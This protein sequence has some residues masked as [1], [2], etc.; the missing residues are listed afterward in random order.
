MRTLPH[1]YTN[2][3]RSDGAVVVKRYVGPDEARRWATERDFLLRL[4]GL[5]PVP[6]VLAARPGE[7]HL[8]HLPGVHGQELIAAGRAG[9][10]LRSC[11][12]LVTRLTELGVT[13]SDYGP[14]NM[15]F[16]PRTHEV[17]AILDWE[18]AHEGGT[19]LEDLAWCEWIV[20][21]HHPTE[22][23][24]L[25]ELYAGYGSRPPWPGRQAAML[26]KC[27]QMLAL[28]RALGADD[29]GYARWQHLIEAT[30]AWEELT[31]P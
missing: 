18:W 4:A 31:V 25:T 28:R 20:R 6:V 2:D 12:A 8:S 27:R 1:G 17:T 14:N 26:A 16:D 23:P 24:A 10:V 30:A 15:L 3:T 9:P 13:H 5:L 19:G 21:T 29:P 22:T 11:G 7:L